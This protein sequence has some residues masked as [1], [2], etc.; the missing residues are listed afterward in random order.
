MTR[1]NRLIHCDVCQATLPVPT[2]VDRA[3]GWQVLTR[4]FYGADGHTI[5]RRYTCSNCDPAPVIKEMWDIQ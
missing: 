1:H 5:V 3:K 4:E 2:T